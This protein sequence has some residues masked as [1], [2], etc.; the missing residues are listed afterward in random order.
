[1]AALMAG[2]INAPTT[3][4]TLRRIAMPAKESQ[5]ESR[6]KGKVEFRCE[7]LARVLEGLA[8]AEPYAAPAVRALR[9]DPGSI[10]NKSRRERDS[11]RTF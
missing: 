2:T 11:P 6:G 4:A 7:I 3:L 5:R 8:A 10:E 1:V 9:A